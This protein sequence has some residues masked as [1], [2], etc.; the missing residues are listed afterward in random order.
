MII[1]N[2]TFHLDDDIHTAGLDYLKKVYIPEAANSGFLFEPRLLL[3]HRQ[4][5]EGGTSY[6]LQ[7]RVKNADTVNHWLAND[8]QILQ[9][10]LAT[11]FGN[12]MM[13]FVTLLEEIEL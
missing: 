2:T 5:E 8:G 7:F 13:G 12:K 10:E 6:S 11:R 1:F 9:K 3:I 4:H